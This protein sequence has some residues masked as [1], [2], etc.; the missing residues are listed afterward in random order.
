MDEAKNGMITDHRDQSRFITIDDTAVLK[1]SLAGYAL[2]SSN[3]TLL[4]ESLSDIFQKKGFLSFW[5][6]HDCSEFLFRTPHFNIT[7]PTKWYKNKLSIIIVSLKNFKRQ[8]EVGYRVWYHFG[9]NIKGA[10]TEIYVNGK[11]MQDVKV[12]QFNFVFPQKNWGYDTCLDE[13]LF[14]S[15]FKSQDKVKAIYE[16]YIPGTVL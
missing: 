5:L 14:S 9:I 8:V 16:S 12:S 11:I 4:S 2:C 10:A 7:C 1:G 3:S 6:K 15:S 13:L